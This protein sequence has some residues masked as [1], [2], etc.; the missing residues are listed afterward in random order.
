MRF[1]FAIIFLFMFISGCT[2]SSDPRSGG[3]FGG[4]H[5]LATGAYEERIQEREQRLERV[6]AMQQEL[7]HEQKQL[8]ESRDDLQQRIIEEQQAVKE[9]ENKS[10][11]LLAELDRLEAKE[12]KDQAVAAELKGLIAE[13]QKDIQR[14]QYALDAFEDERTGSNDAELRLQQLI[15]Q[16]DALHK[17]YELLLELYLDLAK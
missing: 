12:A 13:L 4:V 16:R 17:E 10:K 6:R 3:F 9:L 8:L 7:E 1:Y 2:A 5:G 14:Q 15:E 11:E